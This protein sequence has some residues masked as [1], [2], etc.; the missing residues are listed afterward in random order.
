MNIIEVFV[1]PSSIFQEKITQC[2]VL[3]ANIK[4]IRAEIYNNIIFFKIGQNVEIIENNSFNLPRP[5]DPP[6]HV[7]M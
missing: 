5:I 1:I 6:M 3:A 2:S 4:Q 7:N